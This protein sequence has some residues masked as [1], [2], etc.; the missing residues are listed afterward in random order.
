MLV[1]ETCFLHEF[2]VCCF[3]YVFPV[4]PLKPLYIWF[5]P[6][7]VRGCLLFAGLILGALNALRVTF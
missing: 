3:V 4:C 7:S 6:A 2:F 1:G 5:K